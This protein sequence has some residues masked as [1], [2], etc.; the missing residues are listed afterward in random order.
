LGKKSRGKSSK[1]IKKEENFVPTEYFKIS[2][3][4]VKFQMVNRLSYIPTYPHLDQ[5]KHGSK[6]SYV[7]TKTWLQV[8]LR[9]VKGFFFLALNKKSLG[10][11]FFD[12]KSRPLIN[13][14][15]SQ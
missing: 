3:G 14:F 2:I 5:T 11:F 9:Y 8:W 10:H 15:N 7:K 13:L 6:F 4:V 1:A 12:K